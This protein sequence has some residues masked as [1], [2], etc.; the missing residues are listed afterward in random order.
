[1]KIKQNANH[2]TLNISIHVKFSMVLLALAKKNSQ[3]SFNVGAKPMLKLKKTSSSSLPSLSLSDAA[4]PPV[5]HSHLKCRKSE[6]KCAGD[7]VIPCGCWLCCRTIISRFVRCSS[8]PL[9]LVVVFCGS[10]KIAARRHPASPCC[11]VVVD[12]FAQTFGQWPFSV[13]RAP[14]SLPQP[15]ATTTN[16][17]LPQP[18]VSPHSVH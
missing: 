7:Y 10:P 8:A 9:L 16:R 12:R 18:N 6:F 1:M 5:E 11:A 15:V 17:E 14:P 4:Q 3:L 2:L 13:S